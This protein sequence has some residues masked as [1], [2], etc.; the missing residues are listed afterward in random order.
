MVDLALLQSVSYIAGALGVCVAAIYYVVNLGETSKNRRIT[1]TTTL[2]QPFYTKE[3]QKQIIDLLNMK[4]SDFQDFQKKY[5]ST[6]NPEN[7]ALRASMWNTCDII[8]SQYRT[9]LLDMKTVYGTC[10]ITLATLWIKFKPIVENYRKFDYGSDMF[11]NWEY[12]AKE[13]MKIKSSRDPSFKGSKS[14]VKPEEFEQA[15]NS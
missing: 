3:G 5:D 6:V 7:Y 9:G 12:L 11:E 2:M 1:L 13:I 10:S 15:I 4:W 8:G 14:Y